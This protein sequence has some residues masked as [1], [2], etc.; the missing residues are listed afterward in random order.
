[1]NFLLLFDRAV[2]L[3]REN[4]K[5]RMKAFKINILLA[6]GSCICMQAAIC[7]PNHDRN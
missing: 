7:L 3:N 6:D 1:M 5:I 2:S 4:F